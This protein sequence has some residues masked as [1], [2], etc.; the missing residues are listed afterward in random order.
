VTIDDSWKAKK[1]AI[2]DITT[3]IVFDANCSNVMTIMRENERTYDELRI[4][5]LSD[6]VSRLVHRVVE[7]VHIKWIFVRVSNVDTGNSG[8]C[9]ERRVVTAGTEHWQP[10]HKYYKVKS[11]QIALNSDNNDH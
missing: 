4:H 6:E 11:D 2:I 9:D 1:A 7:R 5:V 10:I 8:D 3:R